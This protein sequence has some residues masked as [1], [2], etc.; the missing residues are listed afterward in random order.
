MNN[1]PSN[2]GTKHL[3]GQTMKNIL[4]IGSSL[5]DFLD[6]DGILTETSAAAIKRVPAWE[7]QKTMKDGNITK[8]TS[9]KRPWRGG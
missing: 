8:E 7:I 1:A 3:S 4:H 6:D 2:T 5:D 9:P